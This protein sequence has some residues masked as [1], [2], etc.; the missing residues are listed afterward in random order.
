MSGKIQDDEK[1]NHVRRM[2]G[3]KICAI[4][5]HKRRKGC[6]RDAT[7]GMSYQERILEV[8]GVGSENQSQTHLACKRHSHI[9]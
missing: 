8:V 1:I 2:C 5:K 6:Q 4:K 3:R 9:K 7:L